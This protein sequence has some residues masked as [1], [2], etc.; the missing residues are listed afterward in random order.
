M[1]FKAILLEKNQTEFSSNLQN[2]NEDTLMQ[3]SGDTLKNMQYLLP[4]ADLWYDSG[5]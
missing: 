5:R 4:T 1:L 3:Q 2:I